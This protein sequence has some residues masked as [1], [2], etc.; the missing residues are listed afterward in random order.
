MF[1]ILMPGDLRSEGELIQLQTKNESELASLRT[2]LSKLDDKISR[3]R[4]MRDKRYE[5]Y[6]ELYD[7]FEEVRPNILNGSAVG[8]CPYGLSGSSPDETIQAHE[9]RIEQLHNE[10]LA[11]GRDANNVVDSYNDT[12]AAIDET[13]STLEQ[14]SEAIARKRAQQR[15]ARV[16][17]QLRESWWQKLAE[18]RTAKK[19]AERQQR[20]KA[21]RVIAKARLEQERAKKAEAERIEKEKVAKMTALARLQREISARYSNM[22]VIRPVLGV[23]AR[24]IAAARSVAQRGVANI[25]V[26]AK[27]DEKVD[28]RTLRGTARL[29]AAARSVA[30]RGTARIIEA[31]QSNQKQIF[32]G[33]A[34]QLEHK[35]VARTIAAA[36]L[37]QGSAAR[38]IAVAQIAHESAAKV[39]V[40]QLNREEAA[41]A[42]RERDEQHKKFENELQ[43]MQIAAKKNSELI[44]A[45]Q[46][47]QELQR[48]YQ[49]LEKEY[50]THA[51]QLNLTQEEAK[52]EW[53][54][55]NF[56]FQKKCE[57][58]KQIQQLS[59]QTA[60]E[61][62]SLA[63]VSI[64]PLDHTALPAANA[65]DLKSV[66]N[67][68]QIMRQ[69]L[70]K[71][72]QK[73]SEANNVV[74]QQQ[75]ISLLEEQKKQI[76]SDLQ[77]IKSALESLQ[78]KSSLSKDITD[79]AA[80]EAEMCSVQINTLAMNIAEISTTLDNI[81]SAS[82]PQRSV[83]MQ[84]A[85]ALDVKHVTEGSK[86]DVAHEV[87]HVAGHV[88]WHVAK[89]TAE[90]S[91]TELAKDALGEAAGTVVS[92]T[93]RV[94]NV[95]PSSE[96]LDDGKIVID[97][98][99]LAIGRETLR[100]TN[101]LWMKK[102]DAEFKALAL[103]SQESG[104]SPNNSATTFRPS[105][106]S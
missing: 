12:I 101:E 23:A 69:Q 63:H 79:R 25:L 1:H 2:K 56:L 64:P 73:L 29:I 22:G 9:T 67:R 41:K 99:A 26:A 84:S 76:E 105:R 90:R 103:A 72:S 8:D 40:P 45:K 100:R 74:R 59:S 17:E 61:A 86:H 97:D 80:K 52:R 42:E 78:I 19:E 91:L 20:E 77:Q 50:D 31:V 38:T 13:K 62:N 39:A 57:L 44:I 85:M 88:A 4:S 104:V 87:K 5:E 54:R 43:R 28:R 65:A 70:A 30:L 36:Q 71:A 55:F 37:A 68:V 48:Q 32:R 11:A 7:H 16:E 58:E 51:M 98:L 53:I 6:S 21:A 18:E 81:R 14:I 94:L 93:F 15:R 95:L 60:T 33:G 96:T 89:H 92:W 102:V 10:Y 35:S 66:Y 49:A 106:R 3:L 24:V 83:L 47:H 27:E 75:K 46:K 34:S 82:L